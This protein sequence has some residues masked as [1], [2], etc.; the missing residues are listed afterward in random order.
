MSIAAI[1]MLAYWH[2]E[3]VNE[4]A[5]VLKGAAQEMK[6]KSHFQN[7]APLVAGRDYGSD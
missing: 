7:S 3:E 1:L 6:N 2:L 4:G 5:A